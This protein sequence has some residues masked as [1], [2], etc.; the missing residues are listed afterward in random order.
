[1]SE[2]D[3]KEEVQEEVK[4]EAPAPEVEEKGAEEASSSIKESKT[5]RLKVTQMTMEQVEAALANVEKN[6]G[7]FGSHHAQS[8]LARKAVLMKM[9]G[10]VPMKKAA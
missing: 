5:K 6:M 7:G 9:A 10:S 8:L 3:K 4:Q 1:M 2:E